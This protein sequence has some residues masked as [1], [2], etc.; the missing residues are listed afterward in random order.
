MRILTILA[1]SLASTGGALSAQCLSGT[2][3]VFS[4]S[5]WEAFES[6]A[7]GHPSIRYDVLN[8]LDKGVRM[9]SAYVTAEDALGRTVV[10]YFGVPADLIL[11][12]GHKT[13]IEATS[14]ETGAERF[15]T[16]KPDDLSV[17]FCL[18]SVVYEDGTKEEF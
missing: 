16:I 11:K 9:V 14:R 2:S 13:T 3:N 7:G 5:H 8:G 12:S 17:S 18:R 15:L 10:Q 6:P 1:F 4:I